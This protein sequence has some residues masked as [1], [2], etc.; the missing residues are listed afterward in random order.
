MSWGG[1]GDGQ[2]GDGTQTDS[3]TPVEMASIRGVVTQIS[4]ASHAS[5][6]VY[7]RRVAP[8][9]ITTQSL[10]GFHA[11]AGPQASDGQQP[12]QPTAADAPVLHAAEP[13]P[14]DNAPGSSSPSGTSANG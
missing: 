2:L 12:P 6:T 14:S 1:N 4:P 13:A 5:W 8:S 11:P 3:A 10:S 9:Q 7:P